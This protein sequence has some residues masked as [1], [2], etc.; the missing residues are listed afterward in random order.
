MRRREG[1]RIGLLVAAG[2]LAAAVGWWYP[3]A[4]AGPEGEPEAIAPDETVCRERREEREWAR[5]IVPDEASPVTVA[6]VGEKLQTPVGW[7]CRANEVLGDGCA[8]AP[9]SA[10]DELFVPLDGGGID[11]ARAAARREGSAGR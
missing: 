7:L 8:D 3:V 2:L 1:S 5:A 10:G 6:Q 11:A 9:L 4:P